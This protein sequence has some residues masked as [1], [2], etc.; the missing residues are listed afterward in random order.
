MKGGRERR[1]EWR[2]SERDARR[3]KAALLPRAVRGGGAVQCGGAILPVVHGPGR[4]AL[5]C[6][7]GR[8]GCGTQGALPARLRRPGDRRRR[9]PRSGVSRARAPGGGGAGSALSRE[10]CRP[11][12]ADHRRHR[13]P[14]RERGRC[15]GGPAQ[16]DSRKRGGRSRE[17]QLHRAGGRDARRSHGG[18][19]DGR[20]ESRRGAPGE[21]ADLGT[22]RGRIRRSC[23]SARR[24]PGKHERRRGGAGD[25]G[26]GLE[27]DDRRRGAGIAAL[28]R[29]EG[30]RGHS[31][32][33]PRAAAGAA[34]SRRQRP[35]QA[36]KTSS[37]R[38]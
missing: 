18:D 14:R 15:G 12:G 29:P 28:R 4:S 2:P 24:A 8:R 17:L 5:P 26:P 6:R 36:T 37:S 33:L 7:R 31:P 38:R 16:G 20:E 35:G 19:L 32:P 9:A 23:A 3:R 27:A 22:P 34:S 1:R 11:P 25:A 10:R 13:R 21:G 30:G